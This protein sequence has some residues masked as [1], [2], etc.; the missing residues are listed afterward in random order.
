MYTQIDQNTIYYRLE[1]VKSGYFLIQINK[2]DKVSFFK[3]QGSSDRS[4]GTCFSTGFIPF[5]ISKLAW[6]NGK[7]NGMVFHCFFHGFKFRFFLLL[8]QLSTKARKSKFTLLF[9]PLL[10]GKSVRLFP[11]A[12]VWKWMQSFGKLKCMCTTNILLTV[13]AKLYEIA[14]HMPREGT[15]KEIM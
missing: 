10:G 6:L 4:E 2:I 5:I 1:P 7:D 11:W 8:Y 15:S 14:I 3:W 13:A 12:L 9:N